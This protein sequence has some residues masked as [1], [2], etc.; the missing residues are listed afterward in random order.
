M[1]TKK[2]PLISY[3]VKTQFV[4]NSAGLKTLHQ[5]VFTDENILLARKKAIEYYDAAIEVLESLGEIS[6]DEN[7]G[8]IIYKNPELFEKGIGVFMR[9]NHDYFKNGIADNADS[10][11]LIDAHFSMNSKEKRSL[12]FGKKTEQKYFD[13]FKLKLEKKK[14][15]FVN[16]ARRLS[17]ISELQKLKNKTT[18]EAEYISFEDKENDLELLLESVCAFL[19]TKGGT[20]IFGQDN[21]FEIINHKNNLEDWKLIISRL[22]ESVFPQN[23][24]NFSVEKRNMNGVK[25]LEIIMTKSE[26]ECFYHDEFYFRN[27]FGNVMDLNRSFL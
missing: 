26:T 13:L 10:L 24:A 19:N 5:Q 11:F 8:K 14:P 16:S 1:E 25:F 12:D 17:K 27:R 20:V 7:S 4:T 15:I 2:L 22:L 3:V 21:G 23:K 18:E 9:L 6:K